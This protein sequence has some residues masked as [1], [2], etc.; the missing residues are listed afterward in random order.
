MGKKVDYL[1]IYV[2]AASAKNRIEYR[3]IHYELSGYDAAPP[4]VAVATE[5]LHI[6][7][8]ILL[9]FS[10]LA[11]CATMSDIHFPL[12]LTCYARQRNHEHVPVM[13]HVCHFDFFGGK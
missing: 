9:L 4:A 13:S 11:L 2:E 12:S 5:W 10:V 6:M 8:E 1:F 7:C 3:E